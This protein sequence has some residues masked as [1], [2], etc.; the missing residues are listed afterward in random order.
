MS[1][2]F[3]RAVVVNDLPMYES[4][5][6]KRA[7]AFIEQYET[8]VLAHPTQEEIDE[9]IVDSHIWKRGD[10]FY[11][12][13]WDH[14]Q[15]SELW[16]VIAWFNQSPTEAHLNVGDIVHVPKPLSTVMSYYLL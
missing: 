5:F 13:A 15:E 10:R 9:L 8:P 7:R 11:K 2:Y 14:Y 6:K 4:L 16:W 3:R 1:R 12:L